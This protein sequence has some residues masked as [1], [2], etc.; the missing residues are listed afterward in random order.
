MWKTLLG[1][2]GGDPVA[3]YR[4]RLSAI[5]EEGIRIQELSNEQIKEES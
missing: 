4:A 3:P 1:W 2:I 5:E